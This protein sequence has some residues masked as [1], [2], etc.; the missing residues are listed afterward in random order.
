MKDIEKVVNNLLEVISKQ[1]E[2]IGPKTNRIQLVSAIDQLKSLIERFFERDSTYHESLTAIWGGLQLAGMHAGVGTN[3]FG[4]SLKDYIES[5]QCMLTNIES[6]L[7]TFGPPSPNDPKINPQF[8][9]ILNQNNE[10]NQTQ[11]QSQNQS[12]DLLV[13]SIKE[14]LTGR[15]WKELV[16]ILKS[17]HT[18]EE[19]GAKIHSA[20]SSFGTSLAAGIL[21][22]ILSNPAIQT[23]ITSFG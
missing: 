17:T 9:L 10:A 14:E 15:Q 22:N 13:E 2:E 21:T 6:E 3:P 5:Y 19:K 16:E 23:I 20:I 8:Q 7:K 1:K 18:T 4:N 11:E 12:I